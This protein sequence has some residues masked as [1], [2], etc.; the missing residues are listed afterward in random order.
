MGGFIY[1]INKYYQFTTIVRAVLLLTGSKYIYRSVMAIIWV[2]LKSQS[3]RITE[4]DTEHIKK[5]QKYSFYEVLLEC[6]KTP[7]NLL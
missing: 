2:W 7:V 4:K 6:K 3:Y 1:F 5:N